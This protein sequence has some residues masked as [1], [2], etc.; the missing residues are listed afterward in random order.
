MPTKLNEFPAAAGQ[1]RY[2]WDSLLDGSPWELIAER[3]FNGKANTFATNARHQASK[4]GGRVRM[5]H[6]RDEQPERLVLQFQPGD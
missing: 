1:G 6:F 2:D 4:R 3:D 5:R